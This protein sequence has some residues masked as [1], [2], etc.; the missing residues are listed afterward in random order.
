M[1]RRHGKNSEG[2]TQHTTSTGFDHNSVATRQPFS[3]AASETAVVLKVEFS[4]FA[5]FARQNRSLTNM[6][7]KRKK[8]LQTSETS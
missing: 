8:V 5:S 7:K 4:S 2:N 1:E 6:Y 3:M